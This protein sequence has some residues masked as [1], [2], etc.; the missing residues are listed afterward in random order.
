MALVVDGIGV[1]LMVGLGLAIHEPFPGTTT[2]GLAILAG[3]LSVAGIV[4][5]YQGL[6]VGRMGVV[7][8]VTGLLAA[9]I[10]VT[11]GFAGAGLPGP[12]VVIG[13]GL[14]LIAVILV[15]R[16]HDPD[17]RPSGIEY[18]IVGDRKSTRLNSSHSRA[19]RMPSSA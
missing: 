7:A 13:I 18:G 17:G 11:V 5:L 6:A 4:G 9:S 2:L 12:E 16:S 19:S 8:P 14:A 15:S 3:I 10:P 1:L